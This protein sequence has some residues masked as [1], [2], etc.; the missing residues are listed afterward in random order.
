MKFQD[1]YNTLSARLGF[2]TDS[3]EI[4]LLQTIL[5]NRAI[6]MDSYFHS[7]REQNAFLQKYELA[8]LFTSWKEEP[9]IDPAI[10]I[11]SEL[12]NKAEFCLH[13]KLSDMP[14][15]QWKNDLKE[16]A[17]ISINDS[18]IKELI[19]QYSDY[20]YITEKQISIL[21]NNFT[22]GDL[23]NVGIVDDLLKTRY[24]VQNQITYNISIESIEKVTDLHLLVAQ[25]NILECE[26]NVYEIEEY[27]EQELLE[28][29]PKAINS[30]ETAEKELNTHKAIYKD[31]KETYEYQETGILNFEKSSNSI[32]KS[33]TEIESTD[34]KLHVNESL[35]QKNHSGEGKTIPPFD[36][37]NV[38]GRIDFYGFNSEVVETIEYTSKESYLNAIKKELDYNPSGFKAQTLIN[39]PELRK[40]VDD[41]KYDAFGTENPH[42]LESYIDIS[43]RGVQ[44]PTFTYKQPGIKQIAESGSKSLIADIGNGK[45]DNYRIVDQATNT[46]KPLILENMEISKQPV[47]SLKKILSGGKAELADSKGIT[48]LYSL[49]NG[50]TGYALTLGKQLLGSMDAGAEA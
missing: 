31:L 21:K 11:K 42:S 8:D 1:L 29:F 34:A 36:N 10:K 6:G 13:A 17:N 20:T 45:T 30:L 9:L 32:S 15:H 3:R 47:D 5:D 39:D 27:Y 50:P 49:A 19:G 33:I 24:A 43:N 48:N 44:K 26:V 2:L 18:R 14:M 25:E 4:E 41:I 23:F 28:R 12:C 7:A 46:T 16:F 37:K 40:S 35:Y 38:I 22:S